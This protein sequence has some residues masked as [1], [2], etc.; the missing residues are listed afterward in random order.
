MKHAHVRDRGERMRWVSIEVGLFILSLAFLLSLY[1]PE[2]RDQPW[3]IITILEASPTGYLALS[4]GILLRSVLPS[5]IGLTFSVIGYVRELKSPTGVLGWAFPLML[6]GFFFFIW[7]T[8]GLY[9]YHNSYLDALV[10]AELSPFGS[11][12]VKDS[13][14]IVYATACGARIIWLFTGVLFMFSP[15]FRMIIRK[16][17]T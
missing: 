2:I 12:Y 4:E 6:F 1:F 16:K 14:G 10:E 15:V 7:G 3:R 11:T 9:F 13:I 5:A 17:Q 8:W